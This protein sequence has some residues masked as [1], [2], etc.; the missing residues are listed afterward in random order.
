MIIERDMQPT[1]PIWIS[2]TI[3][4]IFHGFQFGTITVSFEAIPNLI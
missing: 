1:E 3:L 2:K 4:G